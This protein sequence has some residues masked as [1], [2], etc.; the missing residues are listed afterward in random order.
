MDQ[1]TKKWLIAAACLVVTGIIL[2]G[3]IMTM[4]NW[5]FGK[6]STVKYET[7][8]HIIND[9]F[10][11]ISLSADTADITFTPS[12]DGSCKVV[13]YEQT[14][15]KHVVTT[16]DGTLKIHMQDERKWYS[17]IGIHFGN[18][19]INVYLPAGEYGALTIQTD[20]SDTE[21]AKDF[22]F[23]SI[24]IAQSTGDVINYASAADSIKIKTSTGKITASDI[25][26]EGDVTIK[27]STGKTNL[28]NITC[29]NF[30]SSGSTGDTVLKSVIAAEKFSIK[31]STGDI[32]LDDCDAAEISIT[33]DT[34]DVQGTLFS[35]KVFI[36]QTDTGRVDVPHTV[37]GGKC[38]ITTSTGDIKF[39]VN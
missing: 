11:N 4:L 13:C 31:R 12:E 10:T 21:I 8:T 7:N 25:T 34:G 3:S 14:N 2:M 17:Y 29:K 20:T 37:S 9:N 38:E 33:T 15:L 24:D 1:K 26:C 35:D 22:K 39:A 16:G 19:K 30:S 6:L 36:V 18:P 23:Q 28:T 32:Q 5:N 27:V